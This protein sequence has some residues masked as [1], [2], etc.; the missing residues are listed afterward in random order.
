[1]KRAALVLALLPQA[2]SATGVLNVL[3]GLTAVLSA[4]V[5]PASITLSEPGT[6]LTSAT[7]TCTG[8]G[9]SPGY[10]YAWSWASG[11]S[12]ITINA[13]SNAATT[14]TVGAPVVNTT[15]SGTAQCTV[16]DI[17]P[18][19]AVSSGVPISLT[20]IPL[21]PPSLGSATLVA[22]GVTVGPNTYYGYFPAV[23]IGT[24]SPSTDY[25]G[26]T[27]QE[28]YWTTN[29]STTQLILAVGQSASNSTYITDLSI[30]GTLYATASA[31]YTYSGG[32]GIWTWTGVS[33]PF[34]PGSSYPVLYY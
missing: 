24:L 31:G 2:V 18:K 5:T 1:M 30:N 20:R 11:G 28:I 19:S 6:T 34:S 22:G 23:S 17:R 4:I 8:R 29:G 3:L 27:V 33:D 25:N 10:T 9:G 15:Y 26:Y 7:A 21:F 12:G 13:A 32:A 16:T 14:F